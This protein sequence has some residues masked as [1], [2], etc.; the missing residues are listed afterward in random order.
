MYKKLLSSCERKY[1]KKEQEYN[2]AYKCIEGSSLKTMRTSWSFLASHINKKRHFIVVITLP[3]LGI[4]IMYYLPR[5]KKEENNETISS[6]LYIFFL[7]FR[8]ITS[9]HFPIFFSRS[10]ICI[11][12]IESSSL[13]R[14]R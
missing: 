6:V 5:K 10:L 9:I 7:L 2:Y 12:Q 3:V 4:I 14:C 8:L 13:D 11:D 1:Q